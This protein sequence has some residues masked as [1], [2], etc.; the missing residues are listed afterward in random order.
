MAITVAGNTA[1]IHYPVV[2]VSQ[3]GREKPDREATG[4]V[5][6]LVRQGGDWKFLSTTSFDMKN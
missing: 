1:V 2:Q 5:E 3:C 6:T 4:T